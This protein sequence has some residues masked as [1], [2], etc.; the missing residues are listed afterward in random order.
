MVWGVVVMGVGVNVGVVVG[1]PLAA[2]GG[3]IIGILGKR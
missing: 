1:I 3:L 2:S